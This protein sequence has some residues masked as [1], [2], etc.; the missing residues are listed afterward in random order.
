MAFK[1]PHCLACSFFYDRGI[2][3]RLR[4][5]CIHPSYLYPR[6]SSNARGTICNLIPSDCVATSPRWC[7]LRDHKVKK[8]PLD[9]VD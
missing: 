7:P 2:G 6:F 4:R 9:L 1:V 8:N 3:F 5:F